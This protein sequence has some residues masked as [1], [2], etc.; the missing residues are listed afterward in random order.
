VIFGAHTILS[1]ELAGT[2]VGII[3][4]TM[5]LTTLSVLFFLHER[6]IA[7]PTPLFSRLARCSKRSPRVRSSEK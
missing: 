1:R 3:L 2:A 6:P 7:P 4:A 5:M